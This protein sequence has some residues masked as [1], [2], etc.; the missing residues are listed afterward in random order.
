MGLGLP[1]KTLRYY[2]VD[3]E[4]E[5]FVKGHQDEFEY[6]YTGSIEAAYWSE[7]SRC[8]FKVSEDCNT[9]N[10]KTKVVIVSCD[11]TIWN[12]NP[13]PNLSEHDAIYPHQE[14]DAKVAYIKGQPIRKIEDLPYEVRVNKID[15]EW[16][17]RIKDKWWYHTNNAYG[18][19][20]KRLYQ[21]RD[22]LLSFAGSE[23]CLQIFDPDIEKILTRSQFWG[24][25]RVLLEKGEPSQCHRN[26]SQKWYENK[27]KYVICTGYAL[28]D[29]GMWRQH[30]WLVQLGE[31]ENAI[32]ETT[33]KRVLY[34]GFV[35]TE[36]ESMNFWER[37]NVY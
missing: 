28:S 32:C 11:L 17:A 31:K 15:E 5:W 23:A 6:A 26:S 16:D 25:D 22:L 35:L 29:D 37:E 20:D 27:D 14:L 13:K 36:S 2:V 12:A 1:R 7:S 34:Y 33:E 8:A 24:G 4:Q 19:A 21:L 9:N 30:T 18:E 10:M 3:E